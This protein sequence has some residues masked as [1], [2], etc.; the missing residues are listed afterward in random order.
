MSTAIG[1]IST[2][3]YERDNLFGGMSP[4][5]FTR[6]KLFVA[7]MAGRGA[8]SGVRAAMNTKEHASH[9][10]DAVMTAINTTH[11][12][13]DESIGLAALPSIKSALANTMT[14]T[15][16]SVTA[17]AGETAAVTALAIGLGY[18]NMR[19][20]EKHGR[21]GKDVTLAERSTA[22]ATMGVPF[23]AQAGFLKNSKEM[24]RQSL[25]SFTGQHLV[26]AGS[27]L[28]AAEALSPSIVYLTAAALMGKQAVEA[29]FDY[30]AKVMG[31]DQSTETKNL[32]SS[33]SPINIDH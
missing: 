3:F 29:A 6:H 26:L 31:I 12:F 2:L 11:Y 13:T 16:A 15:A 7:K 5:E 18:V 1:T 9:G 19:H 25:T 17:V 22:V 8:L 27:T 23:A 20:R 21:T 30:Q 14:N 33:I 24:V 28:G 10:G 32:S 4:A